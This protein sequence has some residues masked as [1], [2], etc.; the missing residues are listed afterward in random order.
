MVGI[1]NL[2]LVFL[3]SDAPS[4]GDLISSGEYSVQ[5]VGGTFHFKGVSSPEQYDVLFSILRL[6]V[7][8]HLS[9]LLEQHFLANSGIKIQFPV[10]EPSPVD[11]PNSPSPLPPS[12]PPTPPVVKSK[13]RHTLTP[14][15]LLSFISKTSGNLVHRAT[16][17]RRRGSISA[18]VSGGKPPQGS[19]EERTPRRQRRFSFIPDS[20]SSPLKTSQR[21]DESDPTI[22]TCLK[23]IE[24][25]VDFLS[26]SIGVTVEPPPLLV[27]LAEKE[28]N[29]PSRILT[30]DEK[31][32]LTSILG[33]SER[34]TPGS[35]MSGTAGFIRHQEFSVLF[36]VH[37]PS[38]PPPAPEA[39]SI[40][41]TSSPS[42]T[43]SLST[44]GRPRWITYRYYSHGRGADKTLGEAIT[45]FCIHSE[46]PCVTPGCELKSGKHQRRFIHGGLRIVMD[47]NPHEGGEVKDVENI[48][49]WVGCKV[50]QAKTTPS[51]MNDGT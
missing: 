16:S 25:S 26:T 24:Q 51:P 42:P 31:A 13:H 14:S 47:M 27:S 36:S 5:L 3:F 45:D 9:L 38:Q 18:Q 43:P 28:K 34:D 8:V 32:G 4:P 30:G 35:S 12:P 48:E 20:F 17:I 37:I 50:C 40:S 46:E 19:S 39:S 21:Q 41:S 7:Y 15:G 22:T 44:C 10:Q 1:L 29:N 6:S 23:S 2:L 49:L 33:W 11:T